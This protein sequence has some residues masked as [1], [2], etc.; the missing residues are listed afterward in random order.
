MKG[1]EKFKGMA[2]V[3]IA[4][5]LFSVYAYLLFATGLGILILKLTIAVIVGVICFV[6]G[7]IGITLAI[8]EK[9]QEEGA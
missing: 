1:T 5:V 4:I 2:M 8:N 9:E 7:W 6:V 3:L